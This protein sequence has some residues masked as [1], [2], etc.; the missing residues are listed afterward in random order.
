[1]SSSTIR[2]LT[3]YKARQNGLVD[4]MPQQA[5]AAQAPAEKPQL[6]DSTQLPSL[7]LPQK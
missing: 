7:N 3:R 2:Q 6:P 4:D 1:M 5:P